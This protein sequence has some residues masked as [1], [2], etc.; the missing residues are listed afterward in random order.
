MSDNS[1]I[2]TVL[3]EYGMKQGKFSGHAAITQALKLVMYGSVTVIDT[4]TGQILAVVGPRYDRSNHK[5]SSSQW[6]S[7]EMV[8]HKIGRIL[9]GDPNYADSWV[10][11][12]GYAQLIV[13]QLE[14]QEQ[15]NKIED[16]RIDNLAAD[17]VGQGSSTTDTY[18]HIPS[19]TEYL[20][21]VSINGLDTITVHTL[22]LFLK[23]Y[24]KE[25]DIIETFKI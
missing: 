22:I 23:R 24:R 16:S 8:A 3:N 4:V 10:D 13:N 19:F 20:G 1:N 14:E 11:I 15:V 7:L 17:A 18:K 12:A 21:S 5:L 25:Y 6:E 9:N 2:K